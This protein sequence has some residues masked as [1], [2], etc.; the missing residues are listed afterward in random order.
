MGAGCPGAHV[1]AY[2]IEIF[3]KRVKIIFVKEIDQYVGTRAPDEGLTVA[4]QGFGPGA[5]KKT[6]A[7]SRHPQGTRTTKKERK[8]CL[9]G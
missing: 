7:P 9:Q 5:Q 1:H 6:K 2:F 8:A 4:G 3:L